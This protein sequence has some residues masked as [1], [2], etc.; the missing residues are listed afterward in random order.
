MK[1]LLSAL[2]LAA[3]VPAAPAQDSARRE[4]CAGSP[5][6]AKCEAQVK[7][8]AAAKRGRIPQACKDKKGEALTSCLSA[9]KR[10]PARAP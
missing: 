8:S 10:K 3:A 7:K 4:L 5:N 2:L 6:A 9:A 1:L